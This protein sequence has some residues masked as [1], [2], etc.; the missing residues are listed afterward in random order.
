M[1][2]HK[3]WLTPMEFELLYS[4]TKE[5]QA[6]KRMKSSKSGLP[7]SKIGGTILYDR[8]KVD[9]WLTNNQVGGL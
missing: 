3:R 6:K 4:I 2:E 9:K 5:S 7:F 1:L 8:Q